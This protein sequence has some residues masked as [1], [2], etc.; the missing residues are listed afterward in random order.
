MTTV[1]VL[2]NT[3]RWEWFRLRRRIEF[4]VVLG[5]LA[6]AV[7][8]TLVVAAGVLRLIQS[9]FAI[10]SYRY[11]LLLFELLSRLG[12]FVGIILAG[13]VFG[14]DH[15]WGT[16]RPLFARGQRRWQV[17]TAKLVL[18]AS[19]LAV[20][21]AGSWILAT[22]VGLVAADPPTQA[23]EIMPWDAG[24]WAESAGRFVSAWPV[25]IVYLLLGALLCA[26]GRST[27]FGLGVG[28][29]VLIVESIAYPAAGA[30][31]QL[32]LDVN[33]NDYTRW[34]LWGV[35]RG[36]MGR[37]DD[38]GSWVFLPAV[39]AYAAAFIALAVLVTE[40]RDVVSGNG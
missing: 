35:T 24:S 27:A 26:V 31:S 17:V 34:T 2:T 10:P 5:L 19:V 30:I 23:V 37:D 25:A 20:V 21:W 16:F 33:L 3:I 18:A 6:V 38:L 11:P 12:P 22:A 15:G 29:A 1:A 9:D 4:W 32:A 40:R 7:V 14:S 8:G 13:M 39:A 36:L 28:I